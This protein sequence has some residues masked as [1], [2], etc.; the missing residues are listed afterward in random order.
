M[1]LKNQKRGYVN[2]KNVGTSHSPGDFV[3]AEVDVIVL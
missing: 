3:R 1:K 2:E